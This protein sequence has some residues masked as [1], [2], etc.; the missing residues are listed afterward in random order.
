MSTPRYAWS[1][2]GFAVERPAYDVP[3]IWCYASRY[4]YRP[5]EL[6]DLHVHTTAPR[7]DVRV[8]RDGAEPREV[9]SA[10]D[11]AGELHKTPENAYEQGCGWPVSVSVPVQEDWES[12]LYL[13]IVGIDVD[14]SRVER[15]AFF[16]V[17]P[18]RPRSPYALVLTT[19][20][21]TAYNDWGGANHYRGL[22]YTGIDDG[23]DV[24]APVLSTQRP[25]ARGM[26][27]LPVNAPRSSNPTTPTIDERPRHP[28][29]EWAHV[30]GYSRHF[31]DAFWATYERH[32]VVWA[33]RNGYSFDYLTQHDLHEDPAALEGYDC[34]VV[35]GHDE[36]WTWEMRDV[37]DAFVDAGG[38]LARF[39]GNFLWQIRLDDDGHTQTCYKD[40]SLDPFLD[41]DPAR[42][43][44]VWDAPVVGRP[45][46]ETV[47][48]TGLGG[49]YTRYGSAAPR[50][51]GGYTVYRPRHWALDGT[52]L[53]YG[54][55]FGSAPVC[56]AAFEVDG[57]DYTFHRGLPYPTHSDGAPQGL[58]IIAMA[59]AVH[60]EQ[61][62]WDGQVPLGAPASEVTGLFQAL[63]GDDRPD[64]F[65]GEFYGAGMM[66]SFARGG[67]EV[68]N[69]G[70]TEWVNGLIHRD[71]FT[72]QITHN[73]LRRLGRRTNGA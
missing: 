30:H 27:R 43:T 46:A 39:A 31:A 34:A 45:G 50:G 4:T 44:T 58:E 21:M 18:Q 38:G 49:V 72:E 55:V 29:Y 2:P 12:G 14:G 67:G 42:V 68:F 20:T 63:W 36:Y 48:L 41:G 69:A 40:P 64:R 65:T 19:A 32:F 54:D 47:G 71:P 57:V 61:D 73:V 9:W 7:Y 52:D 11:L 25:V 59:P 16:V 24:P 10:T 51:S 26:L 33:E 3:E 60:G 53:T 62:K 28:A 22:E 35:V 6:V 1:I 23:R 56:V 17:R 70:S 37:V 13:V 15:E 66:A 5:G 8:V